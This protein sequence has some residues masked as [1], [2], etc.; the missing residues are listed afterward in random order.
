MMTNKNLE[1]KREHIISDSIDIHVEIEPVEFDDMANR[2]PAESSA[3]IRARVMAARE[4][5]QLRFKDLPGI[6]C[7]AQMI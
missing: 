1:R 5:Q 2:T 4:I 3:E 7:N 6:H